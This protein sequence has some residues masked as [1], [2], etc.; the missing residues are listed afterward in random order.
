MVRDAASM[1]QRM[2]STVSIPPH[3]REDVKTHL[4]RYVSSDPDAL[5]FAPARGGCHLNDR[6]FNK[7][8]FKK[9]A[10]DVAV[11]AGRV[12]FGSLYFRCLQR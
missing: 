1:P 11:S 7:D 9:A 8:V 6:V 4:Q 5:L 2:A 3:I 10:K 12:P